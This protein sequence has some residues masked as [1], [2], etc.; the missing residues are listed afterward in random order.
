[1]SHTVTIKLDELG[2]HPSYSMACTEPAD[3][4]CHADWDCA[5]EAFWE[6]GD[7]DG[8]PWHESCY[9]NGEIHYGTYDPTRCN[10]CDWFEGT[11]D[12]HE[13]IHGQVKFDV[14]PEWEGEWY[15]YRVV[16]STPTVEGLPLCTA[17]DWAKRIDPNKLAE[18]IQI[19][20]DHYDPKRGVWHKVMADAVI[21][22]L[23]EL[24][25]GGGR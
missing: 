5:C 23:P 24:M 2:C 11:E 25:G 7:E 12:A 16:S 14:A 9:G 22:A 1:M 4:L 18:V 21:A 6:A 8:R 19:A 3:A 10:I 15:E 17:E 13:V 20:A